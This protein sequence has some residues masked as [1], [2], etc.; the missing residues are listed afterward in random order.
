MVDHIKYSNRGVVSFDDC[1]N[2]IDSWK[3]RE[4]GCAASL[5]WRMRG[6]IDV[7]KG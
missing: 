7:Y 5:R 6:G 4:E 3:A 1:G 2:A